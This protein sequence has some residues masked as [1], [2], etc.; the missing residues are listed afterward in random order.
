[1]ARSQGVLGGTPA[2]LSGSR[3]TPMGALQH[4]EP[5]FGLWLPAADDPLS[6]FRAFRIAARKPRGLDVL[7]APSAGA[8]PHPGL[9]KPRAAHAP[10]TL[11][12]LPN[13]GFPVRTADLQFSR[14]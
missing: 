8:T 11:K 13:G 2:S 10:D 1:M 7:A 4:P 6:P 9:Q 3:H 5:R 12:I 14:C